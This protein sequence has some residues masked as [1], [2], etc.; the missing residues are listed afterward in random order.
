M[1]EPYPAHAI[2]LVGL[3]GRFPGAADLEAFW[4]NIRGGVESLDSLSA[5]D[6]EAVGID[7]RTSSDPAYVRKSTTLA[8]AD[9]FDA[10]FFGMSPREAQILDP[11]QRVFLEC[12]WEALEH[13]GHVPGQGPHAVGVYAGAGMNTYLI[14]Q[15]MRNPE[16]MAAVGGYQLMLG[17]DKDFLCT[18]VS[19]KLDLHGPSVTVQTACSTSLVAVVMACRALERGECD[20]ALAG[21]VSIPAPQGTGYRYEEG[22]ILSP[23]G[24]CRPF[25]VNAAGTRPSAGC[26]V[27]VLKRLSDARADGDTIHAILLGAAI[28]NDGAGKAGYTAPSIDGQVEVI[29]TA[30]TLAGVTPRSVGYIE[31]HGTGTPLG[32]P[33]EIAA[34]TQVF[35]ASTPD[36]GFCRLG[37]LKANLGHLDAAAGVAGLI[38]AVLVL[39]NR[40]FPPLAN[41][42]TANPRLELDRSPFVA[43]ATGSPWESRDGTRLAGVSSFGIG[44]TNAHVVLAEGPS[45]TTSPVPRDAHLLVLSAKTAAALEARSQGL[46]DYLVAHPD[47]RPGDVEFTLQLGRRAFA[48]RRAVIVR[49]AT[50][51][52]E[53]LSP[54]H[55]QPALVSVHEGGA[56]S[57]AFLFS[58]QGSQFAGMAARLY[59]TESVYRDTVDRCAKLLV[60]SLGEDLRGV[61]FETAGGARINDTRLAQPA[62][63]VTEYALAQL[64]LS[65]GVVPVAM[66]GHSIGELVAAHLAGVMSLEDALTVVA[67]R[68]RLMQSLPAGSMAAVH[69]QAAAL[70]SRLPAGVE[71][72]AINAP[73]LCTISG[74]TD[75]VAAAVRSLQAGG[76][77]TRALHTSHAFHSSMM[78]PVLGPFTK[79]LEGIALSAPRIPY[80]SNVSGTWIT[81][82]QAQSPA[83]YAAHLRGAVSFEAGVRAL[84]ADTQL[85][86]LEVGPGNVLTTLA[87]ITVGKDGPKRVLQSIGRRDDT[88]SDPVILR[89][90]AARLWLSGV[91]LNFDG[92]H[93]GAARRRIPLPTY[94]FE[95]K[96]YW[97]EPSRDIPL[98]APKNASTAAATA[99]A[100]RGVGLDEWA[101]APTWT[102]DDV[103]LD[104]PVRLSGTWLVLG[105]DDELFREVMGRLEACGARAVSVVRDTD[106]GAVVAD[107]GRPAGAI[108]LWG[109]RGAA[110]SVE[111]SYDSLVNLGL[112]L[113][114]ALKAPLRFLHVSASAESVSGEAISEAAAALSI[115][116]V[117]VLPV[118]SPNLQMRAVDLDAA[119]GALDF[120]T[121]AAALVFEAAQPDTAGQSAWR[122]D[123]RWSKHYE[124][125]AL[126]PLDDRVPLKRQGV[127]LITGGVGGMG[128]TF[129]RWL[130]KTYGARLLLTSRSGERS[131]AALAL[132]REI[133]AA[134][135]EVIVAAADAA[136]G[137]A[138]AT[139]IG[140]ARQRWGGIDGVIHAAGNSGSGRLTAL[141][142]AESARATFRPKLVALDVLVSLLGATPLDFVAL[143]S[144]INSVYG[145]PGACDYA[146]ANAVLDAC[147]AGKA[148]PSAWRHVISIN[149]DAWRDV[150]MAVDL[151]VPASQ[152]ELRRQYV[153]TGIPP[154][155][156]IEALARGLASRRRRLVIESHGVLATIAANR[157]IAR[158]AGIGSSGAETDSALEGSRES[159]VG[160]GAGASA[161]AAAGAGAG[162]EILTRPALSSEFVAPGSELEQRLAAIWSELLGVHPIGR[163]D[164]FF[165]LGGHSLLA[166][167]VLARV[168]ETLGARLELRDVFDAPTVSLLAQR[169]G[170]E[171]DSAVVSEEREEIEF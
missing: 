111:H 24:H 81:A 133:E 68:G 114:N 138:M 18:R 51:A 83:Y 65:W 142:T 100:A 136:D 156:G 124:R 141:A 42:T 13:A 64:W 151:V 14:T 80:V 125:V 17:N 2:A 122:H 96:R 11:Q 104:Y 54:E 70:V 1:A 159:A 62:L 57:V 92:M 132:V 146:A 56:R 167:R 40:E 168:Q 8:G 163:H 162:A 23:D 145:A 76:V 148:Y 157:L 147:A 71:I 66:L 91:R 95:H 7:R 85:M 45:N 16:L 34:L 121:A 73:G 86:M 126:P 12:A 106:I 160:T 75:A 25:D 170:S 134:G 169:I 9:L 93:T 53:A 32:D 82:K 30:Q 143:M 6:L 105:D 61:M 48:H 94:P 109:L 49:S 150:G 29:A 4:R 110:S 102:S 27:V 137:M 98:I 115:G 97:V 74:T 43:S 119:D 55:K 63:F 89:E 84:A 20:V 31:A 108:H 60:A 116:P 3:A 117:L 46:R 118:E 37:S 39:K 28:N 36:T 112:A 127:Y 52:V 130:A 26:G 135:G 120:R 41:F 90:T 101:F 72:A 128:S 107:V 99:A 139:A 154:Q 164:D 158:S 44:G 35:R 144:S 103:S 21:G 165:E 113:G 5:A 152:R 123:R 155:V 77:E 88:R 69:M 140:L 10:G 166:T 50:E 79:V 58:G 131:P 129:A 78:E 171:A 87:R 153:E 59:D 38:K 33:I 15:I 149:W 47:A 19:Y 22:M 67:A 161:G